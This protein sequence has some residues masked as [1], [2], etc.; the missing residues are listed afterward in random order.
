[1]SCSAA[2]IKDLKIIESRAE[3]AEQTHSTVAVSK[4]LKKA[5]RAT[6]CENL[7]ANPT[8][9]GMMQYCM[10]AMYVAMVCRDMSIHALVVT[11]PGAWQPKLF[12]DIQL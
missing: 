2:D 5:Q 9:S 10:P 12:A 3:P 7:Q 4:N 1:M 8:S 11:V 6:V